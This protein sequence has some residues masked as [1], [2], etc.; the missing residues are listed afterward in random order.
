MVLPAI[1]V[2]A[3]VLDKHAV[4][5]AN[6]HYVRLDRLPSGFL[7]YQRIFVTYMD[8]L[9]GYV[10]FISK[11]RKKDDSEAIQLINSCKT[12]IL[13]LKVEDIT[14]IKKCFDEMLVNGIKQ[15]AHSETA[16][17]YYCHTTN[18]SIPSTIFTTR[19]MCSICEDTVVKTINSRGE[20]IIVVS[21]KE[22]KNSWTRHDP[23]SKVKK[24]VID[25]DV[26][27]NAQFSSLTDEKK[28]LELKIEC[29]K[30]LSPRGICLLFQQMEIPPQFS[31]GF[32]I[33]EDY[34]DMALGDKKK[35][36][37]R[38][39]MAAYALDSKLIILNV[40]IRIYQC[41]FT[42]NYLEMKTDIISETKELIE[43]PLFSH[44][45]QQLLQ[46]YMEYMSNQLKPNS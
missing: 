1:T 22:H 15:Y 4:E 35:K 29:E 21:A 7:D 32:S 46:A 27:F 37:K 16:F 25:T 2:A 13:S 9:K 33:P 43:S 14:Q 19:D 39:L 17:L 42:Q 3:P 24:V 34:F 38:N 26:R 30:L 12:K 41:I 6:K 31:E 28:A 11:I 40:L 23:S 18:I 5:M 45:N 44:I 20:P 8:K 10:S 36:I